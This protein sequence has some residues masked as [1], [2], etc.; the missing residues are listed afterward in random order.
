MIDYLKA[1]EARLPKLLQNLDNWQSKLVVYEKPMVERLW[2]QDGENRI[3]LH[4]I[5]QCSA[6]DAYFHTHPWPSA[7]RIIKGQYE[8]K[9]GINDTIASTLF[10]APKSIYEMLDPNAAHSVRPITDTVLSL[11]VTGPVFESTEKAVSPPNVELP[12]NMIKSLIGDFRK[13]YP[14]KY[15]AY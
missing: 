8:M 14:V 3:Y 11:M 4:R 2:M 6:E 15:G 9:L 7:I 13:V 10:M 5:H 1:V 12:A